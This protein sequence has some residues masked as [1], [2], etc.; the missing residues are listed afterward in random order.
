M[1]SKI[2]FESS[3]AK[4]TLPEF[5]Y[6]PLENIWV[7]VAAE[8]NKR[9]LPLREKLI[10]D[11]P[12]ECPFCAGHESETPPE[13]WRLPDEKKGKNSSAWKI[14]VIP[15]KY[16]AL[17]DNLAGRWSEYGLYE[18][19]EGTG[20]H[21]VIIETPEHDIFFEEL[22]KV[23]IEEVLRTYRARIKTLYQDPKIKYALLFKNQ[24]A[25]AGASMTHPH[26]QLIGMP[27][28]PK[29][30]ASK[31]ER[32]FNYYRKTSR[33]LICDLIKQEKEEGSRWIFS[34]KGIAAFVPY[35]ARF[36]YEIF[37]VPEKHCHCYTQA[38]DEI[39][40]SLSEVLK[41]LLLRL[42]ELLK[43][44]PY[45]L[46]MNTA[47]NTRFKLK[48][49]PEK[50]EKKFFR[51]SSHM[52]YDYYHWHLNIFPRLNPIAAFEWSSGFSINSVPPEVSA[53]ALRRDL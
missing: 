20:A 27:V 21:E 36:P 23:H 14:R 38:D 44:A 6:D 49:W 24:G 45:N 28:L 5:R 32:S 2:R 16:P 43:E 39:L 46:I 53:E 17:K 11:S 31:L 34:K 47:P 18:F 22:P 33:C 51:E 52:D 12:E 10:K 7:I 41:E 15:N 9:P 37:V 42:K 8:R 50:K 26:S 48:T 40:G 13:I 1:R 30:I 25:R 19:I 3:E 4:G 35:A 29:G